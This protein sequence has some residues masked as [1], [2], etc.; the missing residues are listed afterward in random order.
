MSEI[1]VTS[2][3][4]P[5]NS[6]IPN[7]RPLPSMA[8]RLSKDADDDDDVPIDSATLRQ[9]FPGFAKYSPDSEIRLKMRNIR[10]PPECGYQGKNMLARKRALAKDCARR[11]LTLVQ[12]A[13]AAGSSAIETIRRRLREHELAIDMLKVQKQQEELRMREAERYIGSV[14]RGMEW[15]GVDAPIYSFERQAGDD[16]SMLF[17]SETNAGSGR[18]TADDAEE[19]F[20]NALEGKGV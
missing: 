13:R 2:P 15:Q 18:S 8:S 4:R 1:A 11:Q 7:V 14:Q 20:T 16:G 10:L 12:A 9:M 17:E 6:L 3:D 19:L 5:C